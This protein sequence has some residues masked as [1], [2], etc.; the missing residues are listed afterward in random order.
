M[1]LVQRYFFNQL[2]WPFLTAVA[3]L[4]G[5]ALLTQSLSNVDLVSSY[6]QTAL[7]FLKVTVLALPHLTALL[8][9]IALFVAVLGSLNRLTA[10]SETIIASA[11]GMSRFALVSPVLRLGVYVLLAN[12]AINLFVQPLAYREMRRSIHDLRSDVAASLVT[13]GAFTH[14]GSGVTIYARERGRDGRM[15]DIL[16]HDSRGS[17]PTTYTARQGVVVRTDTMSAMVLIDG[18]RQEIDNNNQLTYT[19]FDRT[20]FDLAEFIGPADALFFKDSDRFLHELV[21]PDAATI[22]RAGGPESAWAEA[23]YRLSSPLY[24]L[25]FA[26]IAAAVFLAGDYSRLG[27]SRRVMVAVGFALFLRLVGFAVQTASEDDG[28]VNVGQYL[29]PLAGVA[30]AFAVLYWP[31]GKRPPGPQPERETLALDTR[32]GS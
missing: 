12:L 1:I 24:N 13:P 9:P 20:E 23:H 3:A 2:L 32:G 7:T 4:A 22:A 21:W 18:N 10:D 6:S 5:L 29:V 25:A 11:S 15:H 8:V 30:A 14:L 28:A 17:E 19:T 26:M 31:S 27:Y 16:I